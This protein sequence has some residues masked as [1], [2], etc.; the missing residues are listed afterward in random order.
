VVE[1][2]LPVEADHHGALGRVQQAAHH[3]T[4][5]PGTAKRLAPLVEPL[6]LEGW[7]KKPQML[8]LYTRRR[9]PTP[10]HPHHLTFSLQQSLFSSEWDFLASYFS[11]TYHI[12]LERI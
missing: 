8:T 12:D 11:S 5:L 6:G 4:P 3:V 7:R 1:Q 9:R 2:C 10:L